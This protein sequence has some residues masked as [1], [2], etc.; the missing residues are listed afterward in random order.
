MIFSRLLP[1]TFLPS[2]PTT[3]GEFVSAKTS[4]GQ[5][6]N[7]AKLN[8]NAAF[9]SYS[10]GC[11]ARTRTLK[12]I[13]AAKINAAQSRERRFPPRGKMPWPD[14]TCESGLSRRA[15]ASGV[16]SVCRLRNIVVM[17]S[18][19]GIEVKFSNGQRRYKTTIYCL[20]RANRCHNFPATWQSSC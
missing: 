20:H 3:I 12:L 13:I 5:S 19:L 16:N 9:T 10:E 1:N 7:F 2:T 18:D 4:G 14:S 8:R 15:K 6:T 17:T 11:C